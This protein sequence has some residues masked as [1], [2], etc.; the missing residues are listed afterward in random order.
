[1]LIVPNVEA[2]PKTVL[3]DSAFGGRGENQTANQDGFVTEE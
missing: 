3:S 2:G 1:M